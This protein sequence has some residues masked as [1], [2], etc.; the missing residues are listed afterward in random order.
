MILHADERV[1]RALGIVLGSSLGRPIALPPRLDRRGLKSAYRRRAHQLHPDKARGLGLS[2]AALAHRFRE[3]KV[4]YDFLLDTIAQHSAIALDDLRVPPAVARPR[5]PAS[6]ADGNGDGHC[7]GYDNGNASADG[8]GRAGQSGS[9][10]GSAH[11]PGRGRERAARPPREGAAATGRPPWGQA[12]QR[13]TFRHTGGVPRRHLRFAQYL[14]FAGV[15]D[16]ATL[17]AAMRWQHRTR[18]RVGEIARQMSYLSLEDVCAVLR[19]KR[20]EER[21]GEAALRLRRIDRLRLLT[22]LGRQRRFDRP[23]GRYFVDYNVLTPEHLARLLERHW[24]HNLA[25]AAA[26]MTTRL[27]ARVPG[28]PRVWVE[29]G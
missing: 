13:P 24:A 11:D 8:N 26:E 10:V 23:I 27:G 5:K 20:L 14:Y 16:W 17:L 9:S 4:A 3:L 18:P 19:G 22:V 6:G 1:L 15:I 2:E 7:Y 28:A 29:A 12:A 25:C 21:F